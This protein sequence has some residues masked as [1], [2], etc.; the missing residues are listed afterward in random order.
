MIRFMA[1]TH[2]SAL[3]AAL[4]LALIALFI[5]VILRPPAAEMT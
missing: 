4:G 1:G 5:I 3:N 2:H